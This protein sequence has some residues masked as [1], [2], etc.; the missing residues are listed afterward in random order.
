VPRVFPG[1]AGNP[2]HLEVLLESMRRGSARHWN[3]WRVQHP[4]VR[5]DLRKVQLAG[6]SLRRFD[7]RRARLDDAVLTR[8]D[9]SG[10]RLERASLRVADCRFALLWSARADGANLTGANFR[11]ATLLRAHFRRTNCRGESSFNDANLREADFSNAKMANADLSRA[12]LSEAT[13]DCADLSNAHLAEA[14]LDGTSFRGA[15]L[16]GALLHGTFI[17]R[18]QT[19]KQTDQRELSVDVHVVWERRRGSIVDFADADDI[20]L[21]QFHDVVDERGSIAWLLSAGT[22]R[23]V[24]ILGRFTPRRKR[25]LDRLAASLR[26][27]GKIPVIYDFPGPA[28]REITDLVRFVAGMSQFIVVD[29]TSANSVPLELQA[30]IPDLMVPV[31]PIVQSGSRVF[32][33]FADLQRRYFWIQQPLS[34]KTAEELVQWLDEAIIARA[35]RAA[36][37]IKARR[38]VSV[39]PPISVM[40]AAR[41]RR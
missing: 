18:V 39:R 30:T 29:M 8:A 2:K 34:Y 16:R 35:E 6:R 9:L 38:A 40:A 33:M 20:R 1:F 28:D 17:R 37:E 12:D 3:R 15:T 14:I 31:L 23:V 41:R 21:A 24:L 36:D 10:A 4:R 19:D 32:S 27:R 11:G 26:S 7:L 5:P 13:F 22:K 25:V